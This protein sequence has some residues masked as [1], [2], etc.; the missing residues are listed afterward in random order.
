MLPAGIEPA[1]AVSERQ[2]THALGRVTTGMA[3]SI[4]HM[5]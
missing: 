1:I 5:E 4:T 3:C 2:Q